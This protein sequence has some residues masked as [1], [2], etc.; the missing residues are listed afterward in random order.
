MCGGSCAC[1]ELRPRSSLKNF[2]RQAAN[3][4]ANASPLVGVQHLASGP[5]GRSTRDFWATKI[6]S[7]ALGVALG[8]GR[9]E[10]R[11]GA[12]CITYKIAPREKS[13]TDRAL[14]VSFV[15]DS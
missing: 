14:A 3:N 1:E 7:S 2:T 10:R 12:I 9:D 13:G 6:G 11:S 5:F 8:Q 4:G 15:G